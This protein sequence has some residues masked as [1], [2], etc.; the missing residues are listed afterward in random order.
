MCQERIYKPIGQNYIHAGAKG[1]R[2]GA[3]MDW[4]KAINHALKKVKSA[5]ESLAFLEFGGTHSVDVAVLASH[6]PPPRSSSSAKNSALLLNSSSLPYREPDNND[7]AMTKNR[8]EAKP[9]FT[10]QSHAAH[11]NNVVD[12]ETENEI[13]SAMNQ[14]RLNSF[15]GP[16]SSGSIVGGG[17][18]SGF[19]MGD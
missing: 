12:T 17:Y 18:G 11:R 15:F 4:E 6:V 7:W 16:V 8:Y 9:F 1:A 3:Q 14:Q 10:Q 5:E 13:W 19:V 2:E